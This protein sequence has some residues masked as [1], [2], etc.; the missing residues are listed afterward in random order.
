[1][2][3]AGEGG[4]SGE[5]PEG[6]DAHVGLSSCLVLQCQLASSEQERDTYNA[7]TVGQKCGVPVAFNAKYA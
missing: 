2:A 1:M 4:E 3:E 5:L 6:F 7:H